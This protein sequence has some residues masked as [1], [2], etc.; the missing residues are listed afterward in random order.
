MR[1]LKIQFSKEGSDIDFNS[2]V[3][4]FDATIQAAMVN[5]ATHKGSDDTYPTRGTDILK[6]AVSGLLINDR[7]AMHTANFA[8]VD[9]VF[10][11][12]AN[13]PQASGEKLSQITTDPIIQDTTH[14]TLNLQFLSEQGRVVGVIRD[15]KTADV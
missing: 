9:T 7:E 10:F 5:M 12:R 14:L 6:R 11:V 8:A 3:T 13:E 2:E 15:L 1:S 4:G